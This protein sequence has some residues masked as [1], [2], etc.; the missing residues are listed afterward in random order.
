MRI[1][2]GYR[3]GWLCFVAGVTPR[4]LTRRSLADYAGATDLLC[5]V[6]RRRPGTAPSASAPSTRK[7]APESFTRTPAADGCAG[8]DQARA[9]HRGGLEP[10]VDSPPSRSPRR[11]CPPRRSRR[12]GSRPPGRSRARRAEAPLGDVGEVPRPARVEHRAGQVGVAAGNQIDEAPGERDRDEGEHGDRSQRQRFRAID[13]P[14]WGQLAESRQGSPTATAAPTGSTIAAPTSAPKRP[15][16]K[17]Q[18][19]TRPLRRRTPATATA[20]AHRLFPSRVALSPAAT[21]TGTITAN[22]ASSSL[23]IPKKRTPKIGFGPSRESFVSCGA[24]DDVDRV[25]DHGDRAGDRQRPPASDAAER[26]RRKGRRPEAR[27]AGPRRA[28]LGS[29]AAPASS[30]N[31]MIRE[32]E[33]EPGHAPPGAPTGNASDDEQRPRSRRAGTRS[34]P[35]PRRVRDRRHALGQ[36]LDRA[37][38]DLPLRPDR[39]D[40][41]SRSGTG[42]PSRRRIVGAMSVER[43]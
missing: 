7:V 35:G 2:P 38:V 3:D 15:A 13:P 23:P 12:G 11:Q 21:P 37:G 25:G 42:S 8:A 27:P 41:P 20:P 4:S 33:R 9:G 30:I 40:R 31:G 26:E 18:R 14:C 24:G 10:G 36:V 39:L 43:T 22:S 1:G 5:A 17:T 19:L 34:R 32:G 16:A 28:A 6:T 29:I